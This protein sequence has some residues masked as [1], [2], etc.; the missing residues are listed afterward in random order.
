[1][2]SDHR[3]PQSGL[4]KP[5]GALLLALPDIECMREAAAQLQRE[6]LDGDALVAYEPDEMLAQ[7]DVDL[8]LAGPAVADDD[9]RQRLKARRDLSE[10]GSHWI[11][12]KVRDEAQ[13]L[14]LLGTLKPCQPQSAHHY[15]ERGVAAL[16][17]DAQPS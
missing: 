17:L 12:A 2:H 3:D 15:G 7:A 11:V 14:Q 4:F 6:G 9:E 1:M 13:A 5:I 16:P 8:A 10:R